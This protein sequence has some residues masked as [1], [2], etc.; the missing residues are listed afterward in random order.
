MKRR[1]FLKV[2]DKVTVRFLVPQSNDWTR[3]PGPFLRCYV[4]KRVSDG[5]QLYDPVRDWSWG[6]REDCMDRVVVA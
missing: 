4:T 3:P 1:R 6:V 5:W 2:G